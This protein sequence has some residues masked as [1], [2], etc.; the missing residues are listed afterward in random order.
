MHL[1]LMILF[2]KLGVKYFFDQSL[3]V[4]FAMQEAQKEFVKRYIDFQ[5][6][7]SK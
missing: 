5:A 4:D 7:D 6:G 2:N 1:S 3:G